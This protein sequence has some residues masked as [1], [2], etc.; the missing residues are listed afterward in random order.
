MTCQ[1][2]IREG[3]Q[4]PGAA[5]EIAGAIAVMTGAVFVLIYLFSPKQGFVVR[6]IQKRKLRGSLTESGK[7][8]TMK[9][10]V[11]NMRF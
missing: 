2:F 5:C 4:Y 10:S 3:I 8:S 9:R 6:Q 1:F 7:I 11:L